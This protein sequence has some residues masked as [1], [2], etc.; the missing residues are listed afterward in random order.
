[1]DSRDI[2]KHGNDVIRLSVLLAPDTQVLL[3]E[4]IAQDFG[5]FLADLVTDG[6]HDPKDFKVDLPLADVVDRL[7]RA[8]GFSSV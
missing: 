2:R 3:V 8:Y 6:T 4:R 1:V 7:R 5:K